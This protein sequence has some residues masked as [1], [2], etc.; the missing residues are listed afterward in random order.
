MQLEMKWITNIY[1][2][3]ENIVQCSSLSTVFHDDHGDYLDNIPYLDLDLSISLELALLPSATKVRV[4]IHDMDQVWMIIVL[5]E[6]YTYAYNCLL[7]SQKIYPDATSM[8][9][10]MPFELIGSLPR[11]VWAPTDSVGESNFGDTHPVTANSARPA[12]AGCC[13]ESVET[14]LSTGRLPDSRD[15]CGRTDP[16]NNTLC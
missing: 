10:V 13:C 7:Y 6:S 3:Y 11:M 15:S 8:C 9:V 16:R 1:C 14:S 4:S 2:F 5:K 12:D